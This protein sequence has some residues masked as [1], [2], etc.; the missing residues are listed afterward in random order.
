MLANGFAW[1]AGQRHDHMASAVVYSRGETTLTIQ[2]TKGRREYEV[3][4][5]GSV[6][7]AQSHDWIVRADDLAP[8]GFPVE[9]KVGD[10]ITETVGGLIRVYEVMR[11]GGGEHF[12]DSDPVGT[13]LRIH[14][15]LVKETAE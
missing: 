14:S 3:L 12:R 11:V 9:P 7:V 6:T 10:R 1:L 13:D 4:Q 15:R 2:A 5:G 8:L